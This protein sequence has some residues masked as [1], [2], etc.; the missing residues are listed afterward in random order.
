ME[1]R[2]PDE[3]AVGGDRVALRV[4]SAQSGG[5]LLGAEVR[6]P[7]GGG[8]PALHRHSAFETYRVEAGELAFYVT[9]SAGSVTRSVAGPGETVA[10]PGGREHTVRN[11]SNREAAAFV[12]FAPGLGMERFMRAVASAAGMD[13]VLALAAAHDVEITRPLGEVA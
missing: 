9:G 6:I 11:E 1:D 7:A 8:P 5:A 4:T 13:E 2:E 10:I 12:V 3:F